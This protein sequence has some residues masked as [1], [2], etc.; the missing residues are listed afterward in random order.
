MQP[1]GLTVPVSC[2]ASGVDP[3]FIALDF[4]LP[5]A[6]LWNV[7]VSNGLYWLVS[8]VPKPSGQDTEEDKRVIFAHSP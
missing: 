1:V 3:R 5:F 4:Q 8:K 6:N 2:S 7:L